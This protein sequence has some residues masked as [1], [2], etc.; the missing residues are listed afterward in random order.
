MSK[1]NC[2]ATMQHTPTSN[3]EYFCTTH[4]STSTLVF[5][6]ELQQKLLTLGIVYLC[7]IKLLICF[8]N[9]HSIF[10]IYVPTTTHLLIFP[11]ASSPAQLYHLGLPLSYST[12]FFTPQPALPVP[13]SK[14]ISPYLVSKSTS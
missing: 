5:P 1:L 14:S 4:L 11:V 3:F 8:S 12:T 9:P 10:S 6:F 13:L 7:S 2:N